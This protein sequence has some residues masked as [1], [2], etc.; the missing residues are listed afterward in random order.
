MAMLHGK[1]QKIFERME[2][3]QMDWR[4][5]D[6]LIVADQLGVFYRRADGSHFV[7]SHPAC[8]RSLIIPYGEYVKKVYIHRFLK[9]AHQII[10]NSLSGVS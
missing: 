6:I 10:Q 1:A 3:H 5:K 2:N 4:I 9:F 8:S 7:L